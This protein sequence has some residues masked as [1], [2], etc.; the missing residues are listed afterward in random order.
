M[1]KLTEYQKKMFSD[2][3][4]DTSKIMSVA[5]LAEAMRIAHKRL[6]RAR[7]EQKARE[8]AD[9]LEQ[10]FAQHPCLVGVRARTKTGKDVEIIAEHRTN[11]TATVRYLA[12]GH[13]DQI[14]INS[15]VIITPAQ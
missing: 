13:R 1:L 8:E 12:G 5:D 2:T 14:K 10:I 9:Q 6:D 4:I 3:K 11:G 7:L 15:L